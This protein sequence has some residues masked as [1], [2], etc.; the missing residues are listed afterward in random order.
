M[1]FS[2]LAASVLL[3]GASAIAL[4]ASASAAPVFEKSAYVTP[5]AA[6]TAVKFEVFLPLRNT[7]ALDTL[8]AAQQN[9]ASPATTSG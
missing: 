2:T 5:A 9:K 4:G 3:A 7:A 1:K 8:L 6:S